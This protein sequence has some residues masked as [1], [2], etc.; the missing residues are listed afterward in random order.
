M[1][2]GIITDIRTRVFVPDW[3][4]RRAEISFAGAKA[5]AFFAAAL[6]TTEVMP[7]YKAFRISR[8]KEFPAG[9]GVSPGQSSGLLL[10]L[11]GE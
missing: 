11:L 10:F 8:T 4:I 1:G 3:L 5:Q 9:G 2:T 6:G 7:C